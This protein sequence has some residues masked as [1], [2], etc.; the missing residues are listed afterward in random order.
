M[1]L[2]FSNYAVTPYVFDSS[3]TRN[4]ALIDA[5]AHAAAVDASSAASGDKISKGMFASRL[6]SRYDG[7]IQD[8]LWLAR[9]ALLRFRNSDG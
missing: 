3:I 4:L 2:M 8:S 7:R 5:A 1:S 6:P 9:L